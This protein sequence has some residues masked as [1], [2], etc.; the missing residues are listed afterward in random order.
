MSLQK[1][2]LATTVLG[3]MAS[4]SAFADNLNRTGD[5]V[6]QGGV[7]GV[8]ELTVIDLNSGFDFDL[9]SDAGNTQAAAVTARVGT[10]HVYTNTGTTGATLF[11]ESANSGRMVNDL[12]VPGLADENM[13]YTIE[14]VENLLLTGT[15]TSAHTL[16][17]ATTSTLLPSAN[18]GSGTTAYNLITPGTVDFASGTALAEVTYDV[19]ITIP[20]QTD[21]PVASGV[22]TDT[23]TFTIMD[24]N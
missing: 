12:S 10:V 23:I 20:A 22:Y 2:V 14:L 5:I 3:L 16:V 13:S 19:E 18:G 7:P 6:I 9:D 24:D 1:N 15:S 4:T 17:D 8:W 21:R 11:V